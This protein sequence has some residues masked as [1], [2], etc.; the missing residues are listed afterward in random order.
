MKFK[1][2]NRMIGEDEEVFVIAEVGHNHQGNLETCKK[3]FLE[4][5]RCGASAVKLQKRSN[6]DLFTEEAYNKPYEN[7]NSF[8]RTYGEHREFLEFNEEQYRELKAYAESLGLI[9]FATPF[10][11]PSAKFLERIG[12]P[13]YKIA[14][15]MIT[16]IPLIEHCAKQGKPMFISTGTATR[17]DIHRAYEK[18]QEYGTPLCLLHCVASYPMLNYKEANLNMISALK[19]CYYQDT[20]IGFSSHESGIALPIAAYMLGAR[21]IEKH[22]TLNRAWKGTDQHFSLEPAGLEKMVRDLRRVRESLGD[23][24]KVIQPSELSAKVKLGKSI[25]AKENILEDAILSPEYIAFKSPAVGLPPYE[26]NRLLGRK[27]IKRILKD[28][29]ITTD[30][31]GEVEEEYENVNWGEYL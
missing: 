9:F 12:V 4:A 8:G 28:T 29:P 15:A 13:A 2:G 16:D 11:I 24:V 14:S 17:D 7:E 30:M 27:V 21:V 18:V 10:D 23:G 22:F 31:L 1:V 26:I 3:M 19:S 5:S 25:Y 20:V 6:K